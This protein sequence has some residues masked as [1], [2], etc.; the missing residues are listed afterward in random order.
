MLILSRL[1]RLVALSNKCWLA[2]IT[3]S[4]VSSTASLVSLRAEARRLALAA[5]IAR[6]EQSNEKEGPASVTV[7]E[8]ERRAKGR[9]MIAFVPSTLLEPH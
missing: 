6:R 8:E 9:A 5:E 7:T 3:L 2:G 4:L 1:T